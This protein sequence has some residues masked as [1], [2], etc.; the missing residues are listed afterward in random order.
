V[1]TFKTLNSLK[2]LPKVLR[3]CNFLNR[4][5][6]RSSFSVYSCC[7]VSKS[8]LVLLNV[9][10]NETE[11]LHALHII[12]T[13]TQS[14]KETKPHKKLVKTASSLDFCSSTEF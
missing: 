13:K 8:R 10:E 11:A 4:K 2:A 1:N 3:K 7:G 12:R 5:N 14:Q 9:T 6:S